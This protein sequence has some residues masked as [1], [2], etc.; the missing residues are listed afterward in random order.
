MLADIYDG[1][2][3]GVWY[4]AGVEMFPSPLRRFFGKLGAAMFWMGLICRDPRHALDLA[5][6]RYVEGRTGAAFCLPAR[7]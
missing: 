1:F 3:D 2:A 4:A 5:I 6:E 7:S